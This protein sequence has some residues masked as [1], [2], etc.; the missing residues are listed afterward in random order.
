MLSKLSAS[1]NVQI[2]NICQ[3][4]TEA[5]D[6]YKEFVSANRAIGKQLFEFSNIISSF[7]SNFSR[8]DAEDVRLVTQIGDASQN[9]LLTAHLLLDL[10]MRCY[11]R[12]Q[13]KIQARATT[14]NGF[15]TL[16][17]KK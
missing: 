5:A 11:I 2:L 1:D 9:S 7:S 4:E 15:R 12:R 14:S 6:Q 17:H 8:L 10:L 13:K 3:Q 16:V